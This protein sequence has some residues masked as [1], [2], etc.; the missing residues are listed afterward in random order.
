MLRKVQRAPELSDVKITDPF[1]SDIQDLMRE[2][3][4]P[5]QADI[6]EDKIPGQEKS[7]AIENF[8]IAAGESDE[9]FYGMVFQD[10][11]VYKWLE[12]ASYALEIAP[13][14]EL[15]EKADAYID[16][17][18]RAQQE[19]GYLNSYFTAKE[20]E[21]RWQDLLEC[22]ELY[23]SGHMIEAAVAYFKATGKKKFLEIA[24]RNA[25]LICRRFGRGDGQRRGVP[26]HQEI[27]IALLRLYRLTKN[28]RYLE[29]AKY[30]LD[31][32]GT[33]PEYFAE[34]AKRRDFSHWGMDPDNR[35]Y[36]QYHA[37]VRE[38]DSAEGH[39]VR[40]CY[41]YT[42]MADLAAET[43]DEALMAA[44]R[45]IWRNITQKRMYVTGGI[46]STR[47][48]EAFTVDYDLPND[49]IYAETCAS[50]A[51]VFFARRMLEAEVK[52]EYADIMEKELFNGVL[53]GIQLDGKRFFYVNPLEVI[54]GISGELEEY[55]HVLP[56]R[57]GWYACACCPPNAARLYTSLGR[58][59][60]GESETTI[61]AHLFVGSKASFKDGKVTIK[62]ET[63]YPQEGGA[64]YLFS[65]K[66]PAP[67]RFAV[68]K[69]HYVKSWKIFLN[70]SDITEKV[71]M[72]DGYAYIERIWAD[73]D[74]LELR[75]AL[76]CRRIYSNVGVRENA[77]CVALARGPLIYAFEEADN[78]PQ[79]SA[80]RIPRTAEILPELE[81]GSR[82]AHVVLKLQGER[83]KSGE[84]LYSD[85]PPAAEAAELKA[86]P[87]Y[88][89]GNRG[90]G[91]MR[92]WMHESL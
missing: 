81:S 45:K 65:L 78:G 68:R 46:G 52:G 83:L 90:A 48:G 69:P 49:T 26:G 7:H 13:D 43:G 64:E 89:W 44:C 20:P 92:V 71:E 50:V 74:R 2:T 38:Q 34:E 31:E 11:D 72:K 80:L 27:E 36:A 86:V 35:K 6:F 29:T 56:T 16:L 66:Q 59:I 18:G 63:N 28:S 5:Y 42:A 60:W 32:R 14:P 62:A 19:D 77:G 53:S 25:D 70:G 10:S 1:W 3:V 24:E 33:E 39:S 23:C 67:F 61:Y 79:L 9:S 15:E 75:F 41:M 73:D 17:L 58:Y 21:H 82:G 85:V 12:A 76:E 87:Y 40:A 88:A 51:M 8:K 91:E 30:F 47:Y 37:P 4:I 57:P 54:P 22:H 84:A 55:K